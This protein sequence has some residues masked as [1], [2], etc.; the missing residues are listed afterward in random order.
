[1][2]EWKDYVY[3]NDNGG[4]R[5]DWYHDHGIH[6]TGYGAGAL[7]LPLCCRDRLSDSLY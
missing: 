4:C 7:L 3:P 5:Q 2:G 1:M 6:Q